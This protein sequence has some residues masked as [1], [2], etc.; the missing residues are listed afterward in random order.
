M[1]DQDQGPFIRTRD[2][3]SEPGTFDCGQGPLIRG[4]T[5]SLRGREPRIGS[6]ILNQVQG[7]WDPGT[8]DEI[9][10]LEAYFIGP[11]VEKMR[12]RNYTL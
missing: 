8:L 7:P 6:G 10:T 9:Q 12:K 11:F 3:Q 5:P 4:Q 1:L 2:P